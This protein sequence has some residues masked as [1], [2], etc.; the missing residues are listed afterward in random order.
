MTSVNRFKAILKE[1]ATDLEIEAGSELCRHVGALRLMRENIQAR[2]LRGERVDP[3]DLLKIDVAL[4][5]YLPKHDGLQI[6]VNFVEGVQ[7]IYICKCCGEKNRLEAGSY[8]PA[9][10]K[11]PAAEPL[12]ADAPCEPANPSLATDLPN[13][14]P[15]N[16]QPAADL[17]VVPLP[18]ASHRENVSASRFH[19]QIINGSG[20][21]PPLRHHH[22]GGTY[23]R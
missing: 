16:P 7:G 5:P 23:V 10:P 13:V 12:T 18:V 6:S 15:P 1:V 22:Q 19:S 3:D 11:A 14:T 4:K 9:T 21:T 8:T 20:E 2:L 17:K